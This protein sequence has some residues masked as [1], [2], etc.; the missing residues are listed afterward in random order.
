MEELISKFAAT[1][2]EEKPTKAKNGRSRRQ[3]AAT[4]RDSDDQADPQPTS[5]GQAPRN[6][7][8][9]PATWERPVD[10]PSNPELD[11]SVVQ[12]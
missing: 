9:E 2:I 8:K 4:D 1:T 7:G 3:K 12:P 10:K 5:S 6:K 11:M